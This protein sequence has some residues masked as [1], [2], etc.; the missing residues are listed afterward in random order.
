MVCIRSY[1]LS[2]SDY[3]S[4]HS[5]TVY[6]LFLGLMTSS[7]R[8]YAT[9]QGPAYN[10]I[11]HLVKL[12]GGGHGGRGGFGP[13]DLA[14]S[15]SYGSMLNPNSWG[16]GGQ[17]T[18]GRGG[19]FLSFKIYDKLRVEGSVSANGE[20]RHSGGA[21]GSIFIDTYH[22]DGDG[23]IEANGGD[24]STGGGGSGGR[25]AIYYSNQSSYI[26]VMQALGGSS[27]TDIGAAGTVYIQNSSLPLKPHRLL[28]VV[29]RNPERYLKPQ[30][31]KMLA[32][33]GLSAASCTSTSL[34][35]ANG[36]R[37]STTATPYCYRTTQA[38]L[39]N[40]F[41]K[42]AYYLSVSSSATITV[43][44]PNVLYV[45][46]IIVYPAVDYTYETSFKLS[47]FLSSVQMTRTDQWIGTFGAYNSLGETIILRKNIDKV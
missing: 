13:N 7:S 25:V 31:P 27:P 22:L 40:I 2:F 23:Y 30:A 12:C 29:N 34:S 3:F 15:F 45:H 11:N 21:G 43:T 41:T 10:N 42:G 46:S 36:I 35:Y 26:G 9:A 20:S 17:G 44:F 47:T 32:P 5:T 18:G 38:A 1:A 14:T 4:M 24:G 39:W 6:N 28:K 16:S 37:V 8:G 33:R 19:A